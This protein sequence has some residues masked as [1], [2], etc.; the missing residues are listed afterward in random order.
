MGHKSGVKY[1]QNMTFVEGVALGYSSRRAKQKPVLQM[2][3]FSVTLFV[4]LACFV[5]NKNGPNSN[6]GQ[7]D[8]NVSKVSQMRVLDMALHKLCQ[9]YCLKHG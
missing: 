1:V 9:E 5:R 8:K 3:L 7:I 4:I 6:I 2:G